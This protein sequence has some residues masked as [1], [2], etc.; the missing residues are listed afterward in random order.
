MRNNLFMVSGFSKTWFGNPVMFLIAVNPLA[1]PVLMFRNKLLRYL[2]FCQICWHLAMCSK[3]VKRWWADSLVGCEVLGNWSWINFLS[4]LCIGFSVLASPCMSDNTCLVFQF[5]QFGTGLST[6]FTQS[7]YLLFVQPS[8]LYLEHWTS[9]ERDFFFFQAFF[10]Q[11]VSL[12]MDLIV[13]CKM[14]LHSKE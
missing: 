1:Q 7:D 13:V 5:L 14:F 2:S 9:N 8:F 10:P 11:E 12:L 6:G 3:I 4:S